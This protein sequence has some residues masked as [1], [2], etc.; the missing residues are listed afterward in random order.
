MLTFGRCVGYGWTRQWPDASR[1]SPWHSR[2]KQTDTY[3]LVVGR[4]PSD[5]EL[6]DGGV[7][8]RHILAIG[9][10]AGDESSGMGGG[11]G[12]GKGGKGGGKGGKGGKDGGEGGSGGDDGDFAVEVR[13]Q[14]SGP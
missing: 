9:A 5:E 1:P 13:Y 8:A 7:I 12:G 14:E 11:K 3:T 10:W 4:K 6:S 2:E